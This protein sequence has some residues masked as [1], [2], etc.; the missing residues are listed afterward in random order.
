[1]PISLSGQ[2]AG[3]RDKAFR[4]I[5]PQNDDHLAVAE[6]IGK[7][8]AIGIQG[9]RINRPTGGQID[10]N[11]KLWIA[12]FSSQIQQLNDGFNVDFTPNIVYQ[13]PATAG[14]DGIAWLIDMSVTTDGSAL[15]LA[16]SWNGHCVRVYN[17]ET[18]ALIS[19]IGVPG[20]AGRPIDGRLQNPHSALR[21]PD[22]TI[23]V[24][25]Y[26]TTNLDNNLRGGISLWDI[27]TPTATLVSEAMYPSD[28]GISAVGTTIIR[29]PTR[30]IWDATNPGHALIFEYFS[31][32]IVRVDTAANWQIVDIITAPVGVTD[33]RNSFGLAQMADGTLVVASNVA[34][35]IIGI[36]PV[37]K[38]LVFEI[39]PENYGASNTQ[40]RG[41][42]EIEPGYIAWS[43][44]QTA[45]IYVVCV[46]D[47]SIPYG[48][49]EIPAG[50]DIITQFV[51]D[52]LDTNTFIAE[53]RPD[54]IAD[55]SVQI[56]LLITKAA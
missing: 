26:N 43:D 35:K 40:M 28:S 39:D 33:M 50:W 49:P 45:A 2:D 25:S 54:Q 21:M 51:P 29:N 48:P 55:R 52:Y 41:V 7:K 19:T 31:G 13:N 10:E 34:K 1:M 30:L 56:P 47:V 38:S 36:D 17:R 3:T 11:G 4:I 15:I 42:F 44:N 8:I 9:N 37:T 24:S 12:N 23:A 32:K 16:A 6:K 20:G 46:E 14:G 5:A 18:G 53:A 27:T 22:G